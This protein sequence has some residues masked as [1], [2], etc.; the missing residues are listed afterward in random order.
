MDNYQNFQIPTIDLLEH[1][2][3]SVNHSKEEI[4]ANINIIKEASEKTGISIKEIKVHPSPSVSL[5]EIF[6]QKAFRLASLHKM[7]E[8]LP[9]ALQNI[10]ARIVSNYSYR[11]TIGIEIPNK[12]ASSV[13]IYNILKDAELLN[14]TIALPIV[15][16]VDTENLPVILDLTEL[17]HLLICGATAQGKTVLLNT[18]I[19]SLLFN[20]KPDEL[21]FM[22]FDPKNI[23]F[24][25]YNKIKSHYLAKLEESEPEVI[26][27]DGKFIPN[28]KL[29]VNEM[30]RR[31]QLLEHA[32]VDNIEEF[33]ERYQGINE[34]KEQT[35]TLPYIVVAIDDYADMILL[36]GKEVETNIIKLSQMGAAV[37]IHIIM[38]TQRITC[39]FISGRIKAN[40][41]NRICFRVI[42]DI[43]SRIILDQPG[44]ER[45][46]GQG[47][48]LIHHNVTQL[49]RVQGAFISDSEIEAVCNFITV[50]K[51]IY[52]KAF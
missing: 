14:A 5:Y 11:P 30:Y 23:A 13:P 2:A 24:S 25:S 9:W 33:N 7:K 32:Q 34:S 40:F 29:L 42:S 45:L 26:V 19:T 12:Q 44:A 16:G 37:G 51:H 15:I 43:E 47:D 36:A 52:L 35:A 21:K 10:N 50:Q 46:K 38:A 28:L 31:L 18:I 4:A 6:P 20:K 41:Q 1:N 22:L 48:M 3:L 8:N 17:R 27:E 39:E 49:K